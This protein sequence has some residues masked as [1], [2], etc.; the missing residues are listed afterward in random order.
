[1]LWLRPTDGSSFTNFSRT[2][3]ARLYQPSAAAGSVARVAR[4][5]SAAGLA[6]VLTVLHDGW[7]RGDQLLPHPGRFLAGV[8]G[9]CR[10]AQPLLQNQCLVEQMIA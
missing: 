10:A 1:M 3:R 5:R 8:Q 6:E 4:P 2:G 9:V 7:V